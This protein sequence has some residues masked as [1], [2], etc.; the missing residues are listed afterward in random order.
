MN[1]DETIYELFERIAREELKITTLDFRDDPDED[2]H[3]L[4]V[5]EIRTIMERAYEAG[6]NDSRCFVR[7]WYAVG[8]TLP[9]GSTQTID[10]FDELQDA[11]RYAAQLGQPCFIDRWKSTS[12]EPGEGIDETDEQFHAIHYPF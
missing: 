7:F 2:N 3:T 4:A 10:T 8:E 9:D 12:A 1:R 11:L 6:V 5:W